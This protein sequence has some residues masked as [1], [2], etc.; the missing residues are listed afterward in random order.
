MKILCLGG[1]GRI[2]R[3]AVSDLVQ[4][5]SF[6]KITVADIRPE[7]AETVAA[8]FRD[9]RVD[10]CFTDIFQ[11]RETIRK[12]K[13]YDIVLDGLTISHNKQSAS[14]IAE[15]GCHGLNLNGFGEE[16]AFHESFLKKGKI[17]VPG[18]GMTPGVTN[19]MVV[20]AAERL[21]Q[22][23]TVRVSHGSFRPL[24]FSPSITETTVYEYDPLLPGR[25]VYEN[26]EF[27]QVPPFARPREI[28]LPSP[29]GTHTQYIIPHSETK[30]LAEFLKDKGIRLIEVRG[31]WPS[32]NMQLLKTLY[33]WEFLHNE[34][35]RLPGKK[36]SFGIMEAVSH[37]LLRSQKGKKTEL[38]GY[39]L[40]AEI[41]GIDGNG[42]A[43]RYTLVSTHPSSDGSVPGWEALRAYTRS[44]GIPAAVGV[45][46]I[47][48]GRYQGSGVLIPEKVFRPADIFNELKKRHILIRENKERVT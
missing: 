7:E 37:H 14:C 27:I 2:G 33:D 28:E 16:Y 15:A 9:P 22:V 34:T 40:H 24:A 42:Q 43:V 20:S 39:A 1:A 30:T 32:A 10:S 45:Q 6:R 31:T 5:S 26:G 25:L 38:Y 29:Y 18:F 8:S 21:E 35:I 23:E 3:E 12:M 44:V 46:L 48:E 17:F 36:E 19:M 47:S 41:E 11:E 4:F 13:E